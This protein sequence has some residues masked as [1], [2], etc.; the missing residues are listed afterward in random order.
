MRKVL[1]AVMVLGAAVAARAG[2]KKAPKADDKKAAPAQAAAQAGD[3]ITGEVVDIT[4]YASHGA[5]GDKHASCAQKCLGAG[6]PAGILADGK[7]WVVTMKDHSAPGAKLAAWGGKTVSATGAKLEKDGTH[8][9]EI[10]TVEPAA[11]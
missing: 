10:D 9:F 11:K 7:L 4:C 8:V 6:M 5:M 3:K 1:V 2:D